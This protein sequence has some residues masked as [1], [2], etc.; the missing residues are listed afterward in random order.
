MG[1]WGR[2]RQKLLSGQADHNL[3]FADLCHFVEYE[4]GFI[5]HPDNGGSHQVF[6]KEGI[7]EIIDLQPRGHEAKSYQVRQ[8]RKIITDHAL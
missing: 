4:L 1:K 2:F 7:T 5:P 6:G 8:I 3:D